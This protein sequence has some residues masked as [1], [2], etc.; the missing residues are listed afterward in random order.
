MQR[1]NEKN[2]IKL[3]NHI[4]N[5]R[6]TQKLRSFFAQIK[7]ITSLACLITKIS[8]HPQSQRNR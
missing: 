1:K 7:H 5:K 3:L 8:K 2:G 6:T 4:K